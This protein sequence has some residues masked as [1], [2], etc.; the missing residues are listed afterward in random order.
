M[1][2]INLL[3]DASKFEEL[4]RDLRRYST[5]HSLQ[6]RGA[7]SNVSELALCN[8]SEVPRALRHHFRGHVSL[9]SGHVSLESI[10]FKVDNISFKVS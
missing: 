2:E 5:G 1:D 4:L 6:L 8:V 3:A 10:S 9:E 7:P